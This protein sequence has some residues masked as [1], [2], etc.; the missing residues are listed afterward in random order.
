MDRRGPNR[1]LSSRHLV[2]ARV[3]PGA[4]WARTVVDRTLTRPAGQASCGFA[5]SLTSVGSLPIS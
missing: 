5:P 4:L 2:D 3:S 1:A